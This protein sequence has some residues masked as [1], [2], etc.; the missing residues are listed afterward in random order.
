[1]KLIKHATAGNGDYPD[2]KGYGFGEC[3]SGGPCYGW[4]DTGITGGGEDET[5]EYTPEFQSDDWP[6][7]GEAFYVENN[8]IAFSIEE[9]STIDFE[10]IPS[11]D[12]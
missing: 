2:D 5:P 12:D 4:G 1:M 9:L 11:V 10:E 3:Y 6:V 7:I 8:R